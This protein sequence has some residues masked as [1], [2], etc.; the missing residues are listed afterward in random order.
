MNRGAE[1]TGKPVK[2]TRQAAYAWGSWLS[3]NK[4]ITMLSLYAVYNFQYLLYQESCLGHK[5]P[6]GEKMEKVQSQ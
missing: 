3:A 6:S 1:E 2:A 5:V 4:L